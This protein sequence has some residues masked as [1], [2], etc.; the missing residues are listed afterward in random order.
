MPV[1][2]AMIKGKQIL[3]RIVRKG[4]HYILGKN[5]TLYNCY[6]EDNRHSSKIKNETIT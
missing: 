4:K 5:T 2:M 6:G 1:R 3:A